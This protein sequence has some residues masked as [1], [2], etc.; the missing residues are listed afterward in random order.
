MESRKWA[1]LIGIDD[2][3]RATP[4]RFAR[5]DVRALAHSLEE[6]CGFA[7]GRI[8]LLDDGIRSREDVTHTGIIGA[9]E[10]LAGQVHEED[11]FLFYFAGHGITRDRE[12]YL[13]AVNTDVSSTRRVQMTSVPIAVLRDAIGGIPARE[14]ILILDA[15]R[16]DP[17]PGRS[18][19]PN[20]L[21][22]KMWDGFRD[23]LV[24]SAVRPRVEPT[25]AVL[26][27][28]DVGQRS[29]EWPEKGHSVFNH[30]LVES[31]G[32]AAEPGGEIEFTGVASYVQRQMEN[33]TRQNLERPQRPI[34]ESKGSARLVLGK[35]APASFRVH[36]AGSSIAVE[37]AF[38]N[39]IANLG[40]PDLYRE[41]LRRFP[42]GQFSM[43]A[44]ARLTPPVAD[45]PKPP[46]PPRPPFVVADRRTSARTDSAPPPQPDVARPVAP[47]P[48]PAAESYRQSIHS[49]PPVPGVRQVPPSLPWAAL[50]MLSLVT[51]WVFALV[52]SLV[53]AGFV[54]R[55]DPGSKALLL[56]RLFLVS[57]C[58]GFLMVLIGAGNGQRDSAATGVGALLMYGSWGLFVAAVFR[59]RRSLQR[60]YTSVEPIGL[61]LSAGMTF[62]FH[63]IY[64]QYH[65]QRIAE[66]TRAS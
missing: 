60:Y 42:D 8:Q 24:S 30:F 38:W 58:V 20:H 46:P 66:K 36:D 11:T 14:K 48:Q 54:K 1:L 7:S 62:F 44:K 61:K 18:D 16:N 59:M 3:E 4:L 35:R 28:C 57:G 40:N 65:L 21:D 53:Q 17:A 5:A 50:L 41:Y 37:V 29:W 52:W 43:I 23:I 45:V 55:I 10:N 39:G 34:Y 2:Y 9:L 19:A 6:T 51:L 33:W 31:F 56:I 47:A 64:L 25:A 15:C 13:L 63:V 12:S 26:F 27:A 32:A 49:K 22:R